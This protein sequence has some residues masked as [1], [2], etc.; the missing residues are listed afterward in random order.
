[1]LLSLQDEA[2]AFQTDQAQL[3]GVVGKTSFSQELLEIPR[4]LIRA[5]SSPFRQR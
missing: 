5:R 2:L 3:Q 1:M 4:F